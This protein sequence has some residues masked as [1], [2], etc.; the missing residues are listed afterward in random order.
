MNDLQNIAPF[1]F[2]KRTDAPSELYFEADLRYELFEDLG[3]S[4]SGMVWVD[5]IELFLEENFPDLLPLFQYEPEQDLCVILG[6]FEELKLFTLEF[7]SIFYD[8]AL[9]EELILQL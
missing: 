4:C 7:H 1:H 3:Y 5:L 8:D 6:P 9:L 2:I